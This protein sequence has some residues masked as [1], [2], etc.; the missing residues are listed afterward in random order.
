MTTFLFW[1][2]HR[3]VPANTIA[4]LAKQHGVD[5]LI[6]AESAISPA[7]LLLE[8][9]ATLTQYDFAPSIGCEKIQIFTRFSANFLTLVEETSR[10]TVRRLSLLGVREVLLAAVHLPDKRSWNEESQKFVFPELSRQIR[11]IEERERNDCTLLVGDFNVNPFESG[12]IA[13]QGLH[14]VSSRRIAL[15]NQR[16]MQDVSYPFFYN[17]MWN[18]LGDHCSVPPGTYF[19]R[20]AESVCYFWNT[21]DQVLFRPSLLEMFRTEDIQILTGD[22]Q[23]PL[24]GPKKGTPRLSDHLPILFKLSL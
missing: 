16:T 15:E 12:M 6:L 1:N 21:F 4:T 24:L 17:P 8:L 2:L 20:G 5:V 9:N 3:R 22:T 14:A 23:I 18:F 19:Y 11:E 7:T 10:L 13:A